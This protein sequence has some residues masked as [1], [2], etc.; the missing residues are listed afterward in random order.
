MR[1]AA[2]IVVMVALAAAMA[3]V[4]GCRTCGKSGAKWPDGKKAAF[5]ISFDDGCPSQIKNVFPALERYRIPAT[6][7]VCPEWKLFR[8]HEAEWAT[9]SQYVVLGNHT[10]THGKIPDAA[11]FEKEVAKCNDEIRRVGADRHWPRTVSFAVPGAES[12]KK[13]C[14]ITD[15]QI[16]DIYR[17]HSLAERL[18]W[19]GFP[20]TCRTIPEM[21]AYV[22]SVIAGGGIGHIDFH[23]VGGDWLDPGIEYFDAVM[24]KLDS[25]RADLWFASHAEI[26][27]YLGGK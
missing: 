23:G 18:P 20:V 3:V 27:D 25:C 10:Y 7:Y 2:K 24:R 6:F 5:Y 26:V 9:N 22:D 16:A 13:I 15:E 19:N 12:V 4:C 21:E 17:R 14:A 1:N 11:A 8:E